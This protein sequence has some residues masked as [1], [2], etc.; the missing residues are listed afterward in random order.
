MAGS[1]ENQLIGKIALDII[2]IFKISLGD[3]LIYSDGN[4]VTYYV[5]TDIVYQEEVDADETVLSPKTFT[6]VKEGWKF[7]GWRQD[8]VATQRRCAGWPCH[9]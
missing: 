3:V 5:D 4:V 6:P 1:M 9:E 8:T 2:D 7:A